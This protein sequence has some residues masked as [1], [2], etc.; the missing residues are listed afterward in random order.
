MEILHFMMLTIAIF[1]VPTLIKMAATIC[2][3]KMMLSSPL[4]DPMD[5]KHFGRQ[6]I[7]SIASFAVT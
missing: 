6:I 4:E 7:G 5:G 2:F 3:F 1:G